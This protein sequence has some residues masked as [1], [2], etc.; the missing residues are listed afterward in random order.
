MI[1]TCPECATRYAV[2]DGSVGPEGRT[3]RCTHC[4]AS[5]RARSDEVLELSAAPPPARAAEPHAF[6]PDTPGE[7]L[8]R[9]Y[10]ERVEAK[11][12]ATRAAVTG[13]VAAVIGVILLAL[14]VTAVVFRSS[15]VA[16]FPATAGV[17]A[18]IGLPVNVTGLVFED[19]SAQPDLRDGRALVRVS[20]VIRNV[21][22]RTLTP[23]PVRAA[24]LDG[25]GRTL[26]VTLGRPDRSSIPAG[27]TRQFQLFLSDP[28][29]TASDVD[30]S[31]L[32]DA[33]GRPAT[34]E[35]ARTVPT[36][37]RLRPGPPPPAPVEAV[38]LPAE[39]PPGSASFGRE[40]TR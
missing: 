30:V 3:V 13:V 17:Y 9:A 2:A 14:A 31:F 34:L 10:R 5:W 21:T 38:P 33:R 32:L 35:P 29:S 15:V 16:A 39:A 37:P 1:L 18:A 40:P 24:L 8:P 27:E 36:T 12:Q 26:A 19:V 23:P 11:K 7:A 25:R 22:D 28:P 4:G 6:S 20:G